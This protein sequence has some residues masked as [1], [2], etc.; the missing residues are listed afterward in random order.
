MQCP[1]DHQPLVRG[2]KSASCSACRGMFFYPSGIDHHFY[3][4]IRAMFHRAPVRHDR[5]CPGCS[6]KLLEIEYRR[7]GL[8][9]DMCPHCHGLWFD[10]GER[11]HLTRLIHDRLG[12]TEINLSK[13]GR[14]ED[15][16]V[17]QIYSR[18]QQAV[19][20]QAPEATLGEIAFQV[21]T[22]LP[23]ERNLKPLRSPWLTRALVVINVLIFALSMQTGLELFLQHWAYI[24]GQNGPLPYAFYSMFLH[25]GLFHLLG[26]MYFL[27]IL[28]DNVEDVMGRAWFLIIYIAAGWIGFLASAWS[29]PDQIPHVGASGAIAGIMAAYLLLFPKARFVLRFFV[30]IVI[31]LSAWVYL[32]F[33]FLTQLASWYFLGQSGVSWS[34]HVTGFVVGFLLTLFFREKHL[35]RPSD[36]RD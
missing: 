23:L 3:D 2:E 26:N 16:K 36:I 25:G 21:L 22:S 4:H 13:S 10:H 32:G 33:W 18:Y 27:W 24:P 14:Q 9:I 19:H 17:R 34:G 5:T 30:L 8:L 20:A 31:P 6:N 35:L 15:L 29:G 28:G 12:L 11:A 7:G 1:V